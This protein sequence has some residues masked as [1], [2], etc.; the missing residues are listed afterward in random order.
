MWSISF[1]NV[2]DISFINVYD[3]S[4]IAYQPEYEISVE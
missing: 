3:I 4:F 2:Y 1:I